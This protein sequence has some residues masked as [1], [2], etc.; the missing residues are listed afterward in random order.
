MPTFEEVREYAQGRYQLSD[1][2]PER[3]SLVFEYETGRMQKVVVS[4]FEAMDREWCDFA[5][6]CCNREQLEPEAAVRRNWD[7][8]VGALALQD[9]TY[10]VRYSI[11]L[12]TMNL[13]EFELPLHVVARTADGLE[14][15]LTGGDKF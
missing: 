11:P 6:A 12:A 7:F 9:D 5:S 1:D 3:F 15:E 10:V 8:A 4:R 2:G 13:A 14:R